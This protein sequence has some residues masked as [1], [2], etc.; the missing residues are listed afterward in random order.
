[1]LRPVLAELTPGQIVNA[2][3]MAAI[4][5]MTWQNMVIMIN[6]DPAF[7]IVKR[8][9]M[10]IAWEF[11]AHAV[12]SHLIAEADKVLAAKNGAAARVARLTGLAPEAAANTDAAPMSAL[13]LKQTTEAMMLMDKMR[14]VRREYLPAADVGNLLSDMMSTLQSETLAFIG[15]HDPSG[16]LSPDLR[17]AIEEHQRALLVRLRDKVMAVI[18]ISGAKRAA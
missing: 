14:A 15:K 4:A 16:Q 5:K 1:M 17:K 10:G 6:R 12:I 9:G 3:E 11:D 8:G 18:D 2:D 13:E 7:P